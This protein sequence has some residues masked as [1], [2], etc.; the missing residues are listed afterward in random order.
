MTTVAILNTK[1]SGSKVQ[2]AFYPLQ[3]VELPALEVAKLVNN[4]AEDISVFK[5]FV[6]PDFKI[7]THI[8]S[9]MFEGVLERQ[10]YQGHK[11]FKKNRT[12]NY[13]LDRERLSELADTVIAKL[14]ALK[15]PDGAGAGTATHK[16][17]ASKNL[18]NVGGQE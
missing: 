18:K 14:A 15:D 4:T 17:I 2:G 3:K 12:Y 8:L 6:Y 13:R 10:E 1:P 7:H 9:L 11:Y 5:L 16:G